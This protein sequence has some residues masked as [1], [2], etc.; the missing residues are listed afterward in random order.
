MATMN[1][2]LPDELKGFV[3]SHVKAQAYGTSSEYV[4]KLIRKDRDRLQ[5][6]A[7]IMEGV[8]SPTEVLASDYSQ[9]LR[10]RVHQQRAQGMP[11]AA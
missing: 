5:F 4:R 7:F 11:L 1:I 3:D 2:S 8:N 6:R 10:K 9:Q